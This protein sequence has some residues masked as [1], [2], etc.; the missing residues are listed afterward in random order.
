MQSSQLPH[1]QS[2][3]SGEQATR[4]KNVRLTFARR[5]QSVTKVS[6]HL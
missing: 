2:S 3:S 1:A 6:G 5:R 4:N